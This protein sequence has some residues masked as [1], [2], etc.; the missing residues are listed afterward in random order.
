MERL[1][2]PSTFS[3]PVMNAF[4]EFSLPAEI[5]RKSDMATRTVQSAAPF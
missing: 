1:M 2:S 4:I 3:F 5:S